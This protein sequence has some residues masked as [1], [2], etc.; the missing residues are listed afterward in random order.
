MAASFSLSLCRRLCVA[1]SSLSIVAL[2]SMC[3][4][5][6]S[7]ECVCDVDSDTAMLGAWK[8]AMVRCV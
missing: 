7:G 1:V 3:R 4:V 8:L 5:V 6:S 2:N